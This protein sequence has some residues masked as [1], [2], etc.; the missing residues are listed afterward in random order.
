MPCEL[1]E[2][3]VQHLRDLLIANTTESEFKQVLEGLCKQTNSFKDECLNLVEQYYDVAYGFLIND[4]N[5]TVACGLIGIC[6]ASDKVFIYN[7]F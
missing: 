4:L 5:S 6:P 7:N 1:C 3:L 2:Q